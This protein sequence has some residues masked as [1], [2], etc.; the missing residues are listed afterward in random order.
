[1]RL[2]RLRAHFCLSSEGYSL[3]MKSLFSLVLV[4]FVLSLTAQQYFGLQKVPPHLGACE[5][6]LQGTGVDNPSFVPPPEGFEPFGSRE[7]IISVEYTNFPPEAIDAFSYA[8]D[9]WASLIQT[10]VPI[11]VTASWQSLSGNSLAFAGFSNA[12]RNFAGAPF[13]NTYYPVAL[14]NRLHGADLDPGEP[15]FFCVFNN[16]VTWYFG[17]DGNT[18]SGHYDFVTVVLH[19]L[20]HGLG[21]T[22]SAAVA[23]GVG[24]Y[25]FQNSPII[26]DL[27]VRNLPGTFMTDFPFSSL[28]LAAFLTSNN[29]YWDGEAGVENNDDELPRLFA[30]SNFNQGSSI[31]HL[32]ESTYQ[33]SSGN[34]LM[35]PFINTAEAVHD[36]GPIVEGILTDIGW[37]VGPCG[38]ETV[39]VNS[40]GD[41]NPATGNFT[42]QLVLTFTN[43]PSSGLLHVNG[44]VFPIGGSPRTINLTREANG[45]PFS[46][47]TF[48][49]AQS[50]CVN[51]FEELFIAPE[52]C[53]C[54]GD[55]NG[56]LL[57]N[58][59]DF[60]LLLSDFGCTASCLA[61]LDDSGGVDSSDLLLFLS[62]FG[63]NCGS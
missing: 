53:E 54:I 8:V 56:D 1:M 33:P 29:V 51:V 20:C 23:D 60:L 52:P 55:L 63:A 18:P 19:E 9:I 27:F 43:P 58:V 12:F 6:G 44:S 46:V 37:Q 14:A 25:G 7:T 45:E 36:P 10:D 50:D 11:M 17:T 16:N 32:N 31:A 34:A 4:F 13:N 49:T 61:D 24:S 57:V 40:V 39:S 41:C 5:N 3:S 35:T 21:F 26:Y 22:S 15:D 48:F 47:T 38:I 30:P 59:D 42:V 62:V 2:L 28:N